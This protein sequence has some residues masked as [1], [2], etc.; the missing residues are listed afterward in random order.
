MHPTSL[1]LTEWQNLMQ[2]AL[3][4]E[5][6]RLRRDRREGLIEIE[7]LSETRSARVSRAKQRYEWRRRKRGS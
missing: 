5:Q 7:G 1:T 3:P 2:K 6:E 4:E